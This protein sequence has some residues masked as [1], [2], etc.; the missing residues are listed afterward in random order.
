MTVFN[1]LL[2]EVFNFEEDISDVAALCEANAAASGPMCVH[3]CV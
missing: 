2:F 3:M 1:L